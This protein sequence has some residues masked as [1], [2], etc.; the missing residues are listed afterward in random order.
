MPS[1]TAVT[2]SGNLTIYSRT[3]DNQG[4]NPYYGGTLATF[5]AECPAADREFEFTLSGSA[6]GYTK[7][8]STKAG[9]IN[10]VVPAPGVGFRRPDAAG[11]D[12]SFTSCSN[13]SFNKDCPKSIAHYSGA[14][15]AAGESVTCYWFNVL[16]STDINI[17]INTY[18]CPAVS[19]LTTP[20]V[21]PR[22]FELDPICPTWPL[23]DGVTVTLADGDST[24]A[25]QVKM[26]GSEAGAQFIDLPVGTYTITVT[27]PPGATHAY[28]LSCQ[29][30]SF[31]GP[32]LLSQ[33]RRPPPAI[34]SSPSRSPCLGKRIR[35]GVY[36]VKP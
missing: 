27:P 9:V 21:I 31:G 28:L 7:T 35:C 30:N 15:V 13:D 19:P 6:S 34:S 32:N 10:E 14:D 25:D 23:M 1:P 11:F 22:E 16:D 8:V 36:I 33:W 24:T 12:L 26:T 2:G 20:S 18:T 17:S 4:F 5:L 29:G 3:C